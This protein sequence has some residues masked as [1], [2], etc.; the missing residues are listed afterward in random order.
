MAFDLGTSKSDV[1][2]GIVIDK[3][4]RIVVSGTATASDTESELAIMR[5]T[6]SGQLDSSF[7]A[8]GKRT[9]KV[10]DVATAASGLRIDKVGRI[11]VAATVRSSNSGNEF[12][13]IR[14]L[15]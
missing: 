15:G 7:A 14:L 4:G 1:P 12:A 13:L 5:V 11:V 10:G 6:P 3:Q 2:A 9:I 8:A